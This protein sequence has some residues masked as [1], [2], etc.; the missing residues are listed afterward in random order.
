MYGKDIGIDLIGFTSAKPFYE[1]E[2]ILRDRELRGYLSGFEEQDLRKR[3]EPKKTMEDVETIIAI[4]M[5]YYVDDGIYL[6]EES[7]YRGVFSRTAWGRDYHQ[8]LM[9]K[10]ILL[11][12]YIEEVAGSFQYKLFVDTGPLS[13]RAIAWRAGLGWFGKNN[14]LITKEYGSWVFL[15]YAMIN[16]I[17]EPDEPMR[18]ECYG[19]NACILGCPAGALEEGYRLNAK[20]CLSYITQTKSSIDKE[21]REKMGDRLYG[22]DTCQQVCP[23]NLNVK[24]SQ[25]KDFYPIASSMKPN[26]IELLHI[27][28]SQF[29]ESIGKTSAGWRGKNYIRRNSIIA[30]VNTKDRSIVKYLLPLLK[31]ESTMI[32]EYAIWGIMELNPKLGKSILE[33]YKHKEKNAHIKALIARYLEDDDN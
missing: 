9:E 22:C 23:H 10:L 2:H 16:I 18:D 14:M 20:K 24:T 30:L 19:C 1:I 12:K 25:N 5:S 17:L 4:G 13:D 27:D 6:T 3:I 7:Q 33:E 28:K 8:V 26:L 11:M 32:R 21:S 29:K 15:G 31:D